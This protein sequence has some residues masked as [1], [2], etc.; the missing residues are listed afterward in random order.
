MKN[1]DDEKYRNRALKIVEDGKVNITTTLLKLNNFIEDRTSA[2]QMTLCFYP[3]HKIRFIHK[4]S[5]SMFGE[6]NIWFNGDISIEMSGDITVETIK[7]KLLEN[8]L[9]VNLKRRDLLKNKVNK[10]FNFPINMAV[11]E[12]L[13]KGFVDNVISAAIE[14][15][16]LGNTYTG[17][18]YNHF[19]DDGS[20]LK[21]DFFNELSGMSK[22]KIHAEF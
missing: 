4:P 13:E 10:V 19:L 15:D 12:Y 3:D 7:W 16:D 21:K 17:A 22:K 14:L 20:E 9:A 2:L 18:L 1:K 11:K 8:I 5:K 6:S